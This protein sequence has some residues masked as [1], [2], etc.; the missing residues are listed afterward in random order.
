MPELPEVEN[1]VRTMRPHLAGNKICEIV[2]IADHLSVLPYGVSLSETWL[3]KKVEK[4]NRHGK[5]IKLM[6]DNNTAY[7]IHLRMTG[8][9]FFKEEPDP[10]KH[11]HFIAAVDSGSFFHFS[12]V[13]KFARFV[14][15]A[16]S[17][18]I[19]SFVAEGPDALTISTSWLE[20]AIEKWPQRKIKVFLLDQKRIAGIGNIY[21]DEICHLC[22]IAPDASLGNADPEKLASAIKTILE[23]AVKLNGTTLRDYRNADGEYGGFQNTLKVYGQDICGS[24]GADTVKMKLGGRTS[25]FCPK[26]Q[27]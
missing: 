9:V 11:I 2:H 24:C 26:C 14:Y 6:F 7:V 13:R 15:V 8:K 12:D 19:D 22:G 25:R 10:G 18:A 4:I 5:Y 17:A 16:D 21:A 20:Y 27:G 23:K 1:V 3:G